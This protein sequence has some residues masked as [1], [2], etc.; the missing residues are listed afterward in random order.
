MGM[1]WKR[2]CLL[3]ISL[4]LS[5]IF[6]PTASFA[7]EIP[8][9]QKTHQAAPKVSFLKITEIDEVAVNTLLATHSKI[10]KQYKAKYSWT[11]NGKLVPGENLN[12]Y[13]RKI[14]DCGSPIRAVLN[15][16]S[17]SKKVLTKTSAPFNPKVCEWSTSFQ[18][19][20]N[21][22]YSC[23][24][25]PVY[26]VCRIEGGSIF[27]LVSG[28]EIATIWFKVG[29][30]GVP[31]ERLTTW[32]ARVNGLFYGV[33]LNA[34]IISRDSPS[35]TCC[36]FR[37]TTH[38]DDNGAYSWSAEFDKASSDGFVYVGIQYFDY[39]GLVETIRIGG[40]SLEIEYK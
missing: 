19:A 28:G 25:I 27:G 6:V 9:T 7:S 40:L 17:G 36:D 26:V 33:G 30:E 32:K 4:L 10:P 23:N 34:L 14:S 18:P 29:L 12:F 15:I 5:P 37:N 21:A 16:Y 13:D 35:W 2:K 11:V 31:P 38:T 20:K 3:A 22:L 1:S 24:E 8:N 39:F